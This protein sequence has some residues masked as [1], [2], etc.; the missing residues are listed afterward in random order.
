MIKKNRTLR[1]ASSSSCAIIGLAFIGGSASG[2]VT[3]E[4]SAVNAASR[5]AGVLSSCAP[6]SCSLGGSAAIKEGTEAKF[7]TEVRLDADD[8]KLEPVEESDEGVGE[9]GL[10][11]ALM[12]E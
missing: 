8:D 1:P 5:S 11:G 2:D 9:G 12:I 10:A 3:D 4:R 7:D 6:S